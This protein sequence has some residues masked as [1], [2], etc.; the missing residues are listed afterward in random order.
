MKPDFL[1]FAENL[2]RDMSWPEC[3]GYR[4]CAVLVL[5]G[6]PIGIG[7]NDSLTPSLV[8]HP[9]EYLNKNHKPNKTKKIGLHAEI[10]ALIN[11]RK[12]KR[13]DLTGCNMFVSRLMLD[14]KTGNSVPGLA[15]PCPMCQQ[16]LYAAGIKKVF[17]STNKDFGVL[18]L[19]SINPEPLTLRKRGSLF[20]VR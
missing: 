12:H 14:D 9:F 15:A 2:V 4:F 3:A 19:N 8:Q 20:G 6:K 16:I 17:Y 11:A 13:L 5:N 1:L 7:Y 18:K 10:A